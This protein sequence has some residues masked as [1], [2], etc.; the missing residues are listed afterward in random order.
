MSLSRRR[1]VCIER[2]VLD[3]P[4]AKWQRRDP[5]A[6]GSP[7]AVLVC[8]ATESGSLNITMQSALSRGARGHGLS[9][10]LATFGLKESDDIHRW[11][12]W[13][14]DTYHPHCVYGLGESMGAAQL[15]QSL[16]K[17]ARFCAIVAESPFATFREVAYARFGR[18]FHTGPWLG[19][20]F[21]HPTVDVGISL[22][23]SQVRIE[24]GGRVSETSGSS[25]EDSCVANSRTERSKYPTLSLRRDPG[26]KSQ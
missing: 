18:E 11:T 14:E 3:P 15:L 8:T 23:S 26:A 22:C 9:G 4:F 12:D 25:H 19:R 16:A 1:M 10:G 6:R 20:T 21:F 24:H 13:L 7:I 2:L 17:E 5:I